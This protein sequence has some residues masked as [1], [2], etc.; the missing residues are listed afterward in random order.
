MMGLF[1]DCD[2]K[3]MGTAAPQRPQIKRHHCVTG[4]ETKQ[5]LNLMPAKRI[6]VVVETLI[7]RKFVVHKLDDQGIVV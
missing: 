7:F 2:V 4:K 3:I 5:A 1:T 6:L